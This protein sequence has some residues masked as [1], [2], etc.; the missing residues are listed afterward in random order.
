MMQAHTLRKELDQHRAHEEE[1]RAAGAC[2]CA[3]ECASDVRVRKK[4]KKFTKEKTGRAKL[5]FET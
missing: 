3:F 5:N 2:E 4:R 1:H